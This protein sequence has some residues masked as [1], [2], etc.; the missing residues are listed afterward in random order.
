MSLK[1]HAIFDL[2]GT[3]I[4][5]LP[6]IAQSVDAALAACGLPPAGRDLRPLIGPPIRSILA[7]VSGVTEEGA[8][9]RLERAFR[10]SYDNGGWRFSPAYAGVEEL[11]GDLQGAGIGL[12]VVSNKP[13][14]AAWKILNRLRLDA[15]FDEIVCRDSR[16]PAYGS[17]AEALGDLI[18][19]N[20]L[21]RAEC[22]FIGD[23][24]EDRRAAEAARIECAIVAH[25]YGAAA[26][27]EP[28]WDSVRERF[29]LAPAALVTVQSGARKGSRHDRP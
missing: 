18:D 14:L 11:L 17:K 6:G 22:V 20:R 23:T 16:L 28:D 4:D 25:G 19:R 2:D 12:W 27:S 1:R 29:Q 15:Y 21:P 10:V 3:L 8:L 7:T 5:S 9:E 26:Q 24:G 13:A